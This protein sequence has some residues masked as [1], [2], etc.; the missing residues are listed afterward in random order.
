MADT[1]IPRASGPGLGQRTVQGFAWTVG[2][3]LCAKIISLIGQ[4]ILARLLTPE[5]FGLIGLAYTLTAFTDL[6]QRAGIREVL[7]HRHRQFD[8]WATPAFWMSLAFGA[9]AGVCMLASAPLLAWIYHEP[10]LVGLIVV[11]AA[12]SPL[13][14]AASVPEAKLQSQLR[15][16]FLAK[17]GVFRVFATMALTIGFA[18]AGL[19][20]Y[21][22]V[23]PI[24]LLAACTLVLYWRAARPAVRLRLRLRRW[25]YLLDDSLLLLAGSA[26]IAV[27]AQGDY[28]ILGAAVFHDGGGAVLFRLR[29]VDAGHPAVQRPTGQ[30]TL[31]RPR[32][33]R[34]R[35]RTDARLPPGLPPAGLVRH[36][37]RRTAAGRS[38]SGHPSAFFGRLAG[39]DPVAAGAQHLNGVSGGDDLG[40][41]PAAGPGPISF[42]PD[43]VS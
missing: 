13:T 15:F 31:P 35:P 32:R 4:I 37:L 42:S 34:G 12:A 33:D 5:S 16:N 41:Q 38:G 43:P 21:S 9:L 10:R 36:A 19:G 17:V 6:I 30:R 26:V 29:T 40:R 7:V 3:T 25:K 23:L 14:A 18:W 11:L 22:F 2:L 20:A 28:F 39:G 24:P 1:K 27:I 8:R